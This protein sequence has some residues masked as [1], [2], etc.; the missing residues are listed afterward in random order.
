MELIVRV[1]P[2]LVLDLLTTRVWLA[3]ELETLGFD[4]T[5]RRLDR[6]SP[7]G[8]E[9]IDNVRLA[10]RTGEAI[11]RLALPKYDTCLYRALAR[12][13][14]ARRSGHQAVFVLGVA[15]DAAEPGHAW[16]EIDGGPWMEGSTPQRMHQALRH[17]PS[18]PAR[19]V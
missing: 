2:S 9:P 14:L 7:R 18:R 10:I 15:H 16:I 4:E 6:A 17:P 1:S 8:R 12:Y 5:L 3:R 13:A 11:A 19:E